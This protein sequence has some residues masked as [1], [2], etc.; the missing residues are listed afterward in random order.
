MRIARKIIHATALFALASGSIPAAAQFSETYEKAR[1]KSAADR[2]FEM[3]RNGTRAQ[4][5][6]TMTPEAVFFVHDQR[7]PDQTRLRVHK[8]TDYLDQWAQ[9]SSTW[10]ERMNRTQIQREGDMAHIWGPYSFELD[11]KVTHCG[12]NSFHMI[13]DKRGVWRLGNAS[14]TVVAKSRCKDVG[15]DWVSDQ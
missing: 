13:R 1:I 10:S 2:F 12:I 7:D 3:M 4:F 14:F 15:A 11:G 9:R 5:A 6:D 8:V